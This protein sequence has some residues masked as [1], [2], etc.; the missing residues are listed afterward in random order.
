MTFWEKI[1][2]FYCLFLLFFLYAWC[3]RQS[4]SVCMKMVSFPLAT[5]Q[6]C[7]SLTHSCSFLWLCY[8]G[9][10]MEIQRERT[11]ALYS[12]AFTGQ[13][14][15]R[16]KI[17]LW[18]FTWWPLTKSLV[19]QDG[20]NNSEEH[21]KSSRNSHITEQGLGTKSRLYQVY[22]SNFFQTISEH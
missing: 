11:S 8:M 7:S 10:K 3:M 16:N 2:V 9:I 4:I 17:S 18:S 19:T 1:W 15:S 22:Q 21:R 20:A 12:L 5:L 14:L 13:L 6:Q